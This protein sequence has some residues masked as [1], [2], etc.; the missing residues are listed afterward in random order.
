MFCFSKCRKR[1]NVDIGTKFRDAVDEY[2]IETKEISRRMESHNNNNKKYHNDLIQ[3]MNIVRP[4]I[5]KD[6]DWSVDYFSNSDLLLSTF[7]MIEKEQTKPLIFSKNIRNGVDVNYNTDVIL[8]VVI[9]ESITNPTTLTL[10]TN[11]SKQTIFINRVFESSLIHIN[12]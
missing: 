1:K 3:K 7:E 6:I 8:G 5:E 2:D 9:H 4:L 11:Y 10:E 12:K